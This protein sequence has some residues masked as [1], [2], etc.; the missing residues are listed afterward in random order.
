M[1]QSS[2]EYSVLLNVLLFYCLEFQKVSE[3]F[4]FS[5]YLY[6]LF[7]LLVALKTLSY[8]FFE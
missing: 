4:W 5:T 1:I 6:C 8:A 7:A 2:C 3:S